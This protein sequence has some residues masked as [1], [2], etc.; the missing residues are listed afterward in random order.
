MTQFNNLN[1]LQQEVL[2]NNVVKNMP[3]K[4]SKANDEEGEEI[5]INLENKLTNEINNISTYF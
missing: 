4:Y 5:S 3:S 2:V 1:A